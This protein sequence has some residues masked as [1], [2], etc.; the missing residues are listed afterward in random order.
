MLRLTT[1][2][3]RTATAIRDRESFNTSGSFKARVVDGMGR[4]QYGPN[5]RDGLNEKNRDQWYTDCDYIDY[6]VWSYATPIAW[7]TPNGWHVVDQKFSQTTG[8]HQSNLYMIRA[9]ERTSPCAEGGMPNDDNPGRPICRTC[10]DDP[11]VAALY[12]V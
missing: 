3:I 12:P 4:W 11:N 7:H 9:E 10:D 1:R 6:V 5:N 2:S 8:K